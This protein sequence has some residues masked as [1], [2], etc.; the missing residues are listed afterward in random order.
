[1]SGSERTV[2]ENGGNVT[3]VVSG[4]NLLVLNSDKI[5]PVAFAISSRNMDQKIIDA[6]ET[7]REGELPEELE[8]DE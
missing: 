8:I 5:G 1:M 2:V 3:G 6:V 7:F 4:D